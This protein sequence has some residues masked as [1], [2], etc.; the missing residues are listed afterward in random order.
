MSDL[1]TRQARIIKLLSSAFES[2]KI[3]LIDDSAKHAGHAGAQPEGE[4]H[5]RLT[6]VSPAFEGMRPLERQ[7]LVNAALKSEFDAG[8]HAL[9]MKALTP[10]EAAL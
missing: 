3:D 8:L 5:Y 10:R 7:R 1:L 4:T 9:H 6:I 2:A